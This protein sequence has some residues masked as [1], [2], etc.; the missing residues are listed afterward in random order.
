MFPYLVCNLVSHAGTV[1]GQEFLMT[2]DWRTLI[3]RIR[4][5]VP[6]D[7]RQLLVW[8]WQLVCEFR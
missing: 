3:G 1:G 8:R 4:G 5:A 2:V 7:V 6:S